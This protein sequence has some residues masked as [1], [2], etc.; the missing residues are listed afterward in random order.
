MKYLLNTL[1]AV[2]LL[3]AP[4][5]Y[6][7][8]GDDDDDTPAGNERKPVTLQEPQHKDDA[9]KYDLQQ[10]VTLGDMLVRSIE[11]TE[12]GKYLITYQKA[13]AA[14]T[15]AGDPMLYLMGDYTSSGVGFRLVGFGVISIS[16]ESATLSLTITTD[17]GDTITVP[18]TLSKTMVETLINNYLCRTWIIDNTRLRYPNGNITLA[19]DFE[20]CNMYEIL[21]FARQFY[22]FSDEVSVNKIVRGVTITSAYTFL[23]NYADYTYDVGSWTWSST[24]SADLQSNGISYHWDADYMGNPMLNTASASVEFPGGN[25]CKLT[26][27]GTI[28]GKVIEVVWTMHSL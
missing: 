4:L 26:L 17:S 18:A 15:R 16:A 7:S 10:P 19:K 13:E 23:I 11:L 9:A 27:K 6:V 21:E 8:C 3:A 14:A 24:P 20:G 28:G 1:A 12:S 2:F 25:Q 22:N 5:A